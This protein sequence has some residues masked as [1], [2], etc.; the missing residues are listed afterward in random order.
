MNVV[1]DNNS[2]TSDDLSVNFDLNKYIARYS[3]YT[4]INRLQYIFETTTHLHIKHQAAEFLLNEIKA[5][6]TNTNLYTKTISKIDEL[7]DFEPKLIWDKSWIAS[8]DS[9]F[10]SNLE[11]IENELAIAK[12][13]MS[14]ESLRLKYLDLGYL[15]FERG[16]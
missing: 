16:E 2:P 1:V 7:P 3:G 8:T 12:S 9:L 13:T 4:K 6:T 14:K 15:H 5:V 10:F 11:R